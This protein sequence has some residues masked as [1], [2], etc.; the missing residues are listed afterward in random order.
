MGAV[1]NEVTQLGCQLSLESL[2][3]MGFPGNQFDG[4]RWKLNC[5]N[6]FG[7]H[8]LSRKKRVGGVKKINCGGTKSHLNLVRKEDLLL[9]GE[10]FLVWGRDSGSQDDAVIVGTIMK[11]VVVSGD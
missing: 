5:S 11:K 4:P 7:I 2:G 1:H 6:S 8:G 9:W 10:I 3:L